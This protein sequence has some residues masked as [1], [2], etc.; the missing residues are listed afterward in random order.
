MLVEMDITFLIG[1]FVVFIV[2]IILTAMLVKKS[3]KDTIELLEKEVQDAQ[4]KKEKLI[5]EIELLESKLFEYGS[6]TKSKSFVAEQI[7]KIDDLE[8]EIESYKNLLQDIKKIAQDANYVKKEF[9]S[10]IRH[11]IRTPLNSILVFAD[12]LKNE[13]KD[14]KQLTYA[15]NIA[16]SGQKLLALMNSIIELSKVEGKNF[17]FQERAIDTALFFENIA[18][19]YTNKAT[20]KGLKLSLQVDQDLPKSL[21][22][23][24]DKVKQ[25]VENLVENAIKFTKDGSVNIY[26]KLQS[27]NVVNNTV[28]FAIEVKDTGSGIPIK[29]QKAIFEIFEK[30]ED[31]SNEEFQSVGLGLSV[32]R[33]IARLMGG[34]IKLTSM[35]N[36]GSTFTLELYNVEIVLKSHEDENAQNQEVDFS[37]II[38]N[39][40]NVLIIDEDQKSKEI[41]E[42]SFDGTKAH[43]EYF[44]NPRDAIEKLRSSRFDMVFIDLELLTMDENAVSKVIAKISTAP[45]ITLTQRTLKDVKFAANGMKIAGHLKKPL[46]KIELFKVV[47][48]LFNSSYDEQQVQPQQQVQQKDRFSNMDDAKLEMFASYAQKH[49]MPLYNQVMQTNDLEVTK[50]FAS[51]LEML[52]KKFEIVLFTDLSQKLLE[53]IELFDVDGIAKYMKS[54]KYFLHELQNHLKNK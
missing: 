46:S 11:E 32:H 47:L 12:M 53:K 38:P 14:H 50:K 2:G 19:H 10:N 30:R 5:D 15:Q 40:A 28:N 3:N 13:V 1:I 43:I 34:D 35:P 20:Q 45:A 49:L 51:S 8:Y 9:L 31:S 21:M 39:G 44:D 41:I 18:Q 22:V 36:Q 29:D 26:V 37:K 4:E 48:R 33:K 16:N 42:E 17:Q 27:T 23:D 25:I 52:A 7:K 54:Y 24:S 6:T